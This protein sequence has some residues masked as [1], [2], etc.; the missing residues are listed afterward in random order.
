EQAYHRLR[1]IK[2]A[3][4]PADMIHSNHPIAPAR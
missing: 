2:A 1:R 3:V 4:D